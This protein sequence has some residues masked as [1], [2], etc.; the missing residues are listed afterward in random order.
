MSNKKI[1]A[2]VDYKSKFGS[3]HF[4]NPYRSGMDK[5]LL[6]KLFKEKD[7]EIEFDFFHKVDLRNAEKFTNSIVI[8]TSSEDIGYHYK[9]Y[10]EDIVLGLEE[11]G[12]N[13]IPRYSYLRAN[14]NK[15][16][17]EALRTI[18][19]GE[20]TFNSMHFGSLKDL[21]FV[22]DDLIFPLVLKNAKG[23]SGTGVFLARSKGELIRFVKKF[24]DYFYPNE[25]LKDFIRSYLHKGYNTESVYRDKFIVQPFI[26]NLKND[27]KVY[28][29]GNKLYVFNRPIQKGRGIKASGGGYDNYFY[30]SEANAP[31]GMFDYCFDIFVKLDI[32]HVSLDIAFDGN[33]FYL[34][35]FQALYFGTAGIPY[36]KGFFVKSNGVWSFIKEK[37]C[38]EAVYVDSLTW[39]L[40][41]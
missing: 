12:A 31:E 10:I 30:G 24:K 2:L 1:I 20:K 25:D 6:G 26:P 14:N 23:A 27:W 3:K 22:V 13:L 9:S 28:I 16:Y 38:I 21:L 36:S 40:T 34:I 32:P 4:D 41:R 18:K 5:T 29:F 7:Y 39:Y 8:Y 17:M 11:L 19:L 35:E 15:V 33:K 37:Y